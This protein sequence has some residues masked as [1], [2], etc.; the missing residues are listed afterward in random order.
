MDKWVPYDRSRISILAY[1]QISS[2]RRL[3]Y[4]ITIRFRVLILNGLPDVLWIV[5]ASQ[6]VIKSANSEF[7]DSEVF[8]SNS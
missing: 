3:G 7:L 2:I 8:F 1:M 6:K 5:L 4:G